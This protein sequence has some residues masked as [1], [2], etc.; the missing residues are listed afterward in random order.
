[1]SDVVKLVSMDE[2]REGTPVAV[3]LEGF[4]PLAVFRVADEF[5]VTDN[6]CTH[7]DAALDEGFQEGHVIECPF[8]GGAFDVITGEPTEL[9]CTVPLQTYT[10]IIQDNH[11]C[12]PAA[13]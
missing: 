1:M 10:V 7:G 9:P 4:P 12:I 8:H 13:S 3:H 6:T 11:I 5:F 2:V